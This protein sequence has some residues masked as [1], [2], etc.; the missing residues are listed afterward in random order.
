MYFFSTAEFNF[1]ISRLYQERT[2]NTS[3]IG[4]DDGGSALP[5]GSVY[6]WMEKFQHGRRSMKD[7]EGAHPLMT[8]KLRTSALPPE[9]Q[10]KEDQRNWT[11]V[12]T[13]YF[14]EN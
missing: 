10:L 5:R 2:R 14:K 6:E 9:K 11:V 1:A 4:A 8:A 12:S 13:T 3:K 7:R